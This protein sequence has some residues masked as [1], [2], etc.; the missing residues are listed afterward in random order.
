MFYNVRGIGQCVHGH[1]LRTAY[2]LSATK[3]ELSYWSTGHSTDLWLTDKKKRIYKLSS[4]I[5]MIVSANVCTNVKKIE[6]KQCLTISTF[7]RDIGIWQQFIVW[8]GQANGQCL[9]LIMTMIVCLSA[10]FKI[11]NNRFHLWWG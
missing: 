7:H 1:L 6:K 8:Y 3:I 5:F 11:P 10:T 2:K 9:W 4:I